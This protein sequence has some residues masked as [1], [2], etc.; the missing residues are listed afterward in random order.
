M[1][2]TI[3]TTFTTLYS[4][5]YLITHTTVSLTPVSDNALNECL[6]NEKTVNEGTTLED[7]GMYT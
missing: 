4:I 6:V 5:L 1:Q 7:H 2:N 3:F